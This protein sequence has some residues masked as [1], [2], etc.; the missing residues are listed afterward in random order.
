MSDKMINEKELKIS[1]ENIWRSTNLK[2]EQEYYSSILTLLNVRK[3]KKLLDVA[4]GGGYLLHEA[5]KKGLD[6][7]GVDISENA[8]KKTKDI[9]K[10][11]RL[12]LASAESLPFDKNSFDYITCLG[13]L[14]HFL[15][16]DIGLEE[17]RRVLKDDGEIC[18]VLPNIWYMPD[19]IRGW[20]TGEGLTHGQE[21]ERFYSLVEAITLIEVNGGFKI[22]KISKYNRPP[23]IIKVAKPLPKF[24]KLYIMLYKLLRN[25][26]PVT[27][28]Y[29]F[30]F[31]CTKRHFGA[32]SSLEIGNKKHE[33]YL[34]RGWYYI[35]NWP[36]AVRWTE[37]I[38][39]AYLKANINSNKLLIK[40]FTYYPQIKGQ[41][42]IEKKQVSTFEMQDL[43]WKLLEVAI[44][45]YC[46]NKTIEVI[47][48]LDNTWIPDEIMKNG[49]TRELGI[50]IQKIWVE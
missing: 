15:H 41:I 22:E 14:E 39:T 13:S 38:A 4:C 8:I 46:K 33:R 30:V 16:P 49:D 47:I 32:P 1:Y 25:K 44:P 31:I 11:T 50:A 35:E 42:L 27:A 23:E 9:V 34:G 28:S 36:P 26:I 5:E 2:E 18:I 12:V 40:A 29:V 19:V 37:K 17:M 20:L 43:E 7:Y 10:K 24:N 6:C 21:S 3:N 48:E 45:D